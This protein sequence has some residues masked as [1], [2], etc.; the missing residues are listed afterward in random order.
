MGQN[1]IFHELHQCIYMT[2]QLF[3]GK[4]INGRVE[5]YETVDLSNPVI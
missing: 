3:Y 4:E 1:G 2:G 5:L